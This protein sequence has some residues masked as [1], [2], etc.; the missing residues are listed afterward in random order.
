MQYKEYTRHI[1]HINRT[2][3]GKQ[4]QSCV[5]NYSCCWCWWCCMAA[6]KQ[7]AHVR[8]CRRLTVRVNGAAVET[9]WPFKCLVLSCLTGSVRGV[10]YAVPADLQHNRRKSPCQSE[11][12]SRSCTP[13]SA[14]GQSVAAPAALSI[15]SLDYYS[16]LVAG[17]G[18]EILGV[19]PRHRHRQP[20]LVELTVGRTVMIPVWRWRPSPVCVRLF[21]QRRRRTESWTSPSSRC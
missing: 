8:Q 6:G 19:P 14:P 13:S 7:T 1:R 16:G 21:G 18:G 4:L 5:Y 3:I 12:S 2:Q 17:E 20:G 10:S 11:L 15:H 9:S